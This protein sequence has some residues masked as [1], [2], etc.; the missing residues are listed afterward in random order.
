MITEDRIRPDFLIRGGEGGMNPLVAQLVHLPFPEMAGSLRT[1]ADRIT[2]DWDA[3]VRE[4]MP[5]MRYLTFEE[6]KDST[7]QI[8]LAIADALA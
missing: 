4:A 8:L 2:L 1:A 6:L 3:A 7:P 5:Q